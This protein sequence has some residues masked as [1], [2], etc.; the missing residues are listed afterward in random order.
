MPGFEVNYVRN[1]TDVDDKIIKRANE[2]GI[3]SKELA[4]EFIRAFDEDMARLGLRAPTCQPKATE[5]IA[6]IIALVE[7]LIERGDGLCRQGGTSTS[8]SRSFPHYLKLS[9]RNLEEMQVGR[10][11]CPRRT[12]TQSDGFRSL[13]GSQ[14]RR[15]DLG[16]PLGAGP[17]RLAY[18]ML[19]HEHV[20]FLATPSIS[21]AAART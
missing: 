18:R 20:N 8:R 5:H 15:T 21:T 10:P 14:T 13:E 16:L 6:Q 9:K 2:R 17:A 4:E 12:Q 1:Y 7:P 3:A 11:H 19:G